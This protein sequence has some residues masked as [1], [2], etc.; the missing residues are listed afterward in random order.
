MIGLK[1]KNSNMKLILIFLI[2]S[3]F[4]LMAQE[5]CLPREQV[6]ALL[7]DAKTLLIV[8]EEVTLKDSIISSQEL[9]IV[10]QDSTINLLNQKIALSDSLV[11]D[12]HEIIADNTAW[13]K[14]YLQL[15]VV[16]LSGIGVG[17]L[18]K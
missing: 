2:I 18:I 17:D 3:C 16:F 5:I 10:Q 7:L 4:D 12:S 14:K 13:Y 8:Q 9:T 11:Q 6:E 15:L 1:I